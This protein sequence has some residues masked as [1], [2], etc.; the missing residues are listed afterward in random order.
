MDLEMLTEVASS[1]F[2]WAILCIIL[3]ASVI[4]EMRKENVKREEDLLEFYQA[5]RTES[6][7]REAAL[8]V[9][10]RRSNDSQEQ[11]VS[12]LHTMNETIGKIEGRVDRMEKKMYNC[13]K[14][15]MQYVEGW[16]KS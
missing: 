9:H 1:Q 2:V 10:L 8:L 11:T 6:I 14:G 15:G 7:E 13:N 12:T 16:P 5:Y 4:R 3:A